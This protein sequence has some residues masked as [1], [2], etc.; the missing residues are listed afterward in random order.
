MTAQERIELLVD[1]GS[2][3]EDNEEITAEDPLHFH[4]GG[5]PYQ[6]SLRQARRETGLNE[7]IVTGHAR[8]GGQPVQ[9]AVFD[10]RFMGGSMSGAV[11]EK[12][13]RAAERAVGE[14]KPLLIVTSTGGARIQEGMLALV[15][16]AKTASAV[17]R[18]HKAEVPFFVVLAHPTTGGVFASFAS[19]A[20]VLLAEPKA[21]IGFAGPRVVE[22]LTQ[23]PLPP[24][25]HRAE[26]QFEH[27]LVDGV[28]DRRELREMLHDL[29][30]HTQVR[31][32]PTPVGEEAD[33]P[34]PRRGRPRWGPWKLVRQARRLDRPTAADYLEHVVEEFVPLHGDRLGHDDPAIVGGPGRIGEHS[35]M[36]V[37][38]ERSV[39]TNITPG[40]YRKAQR[41]MRLAAK[42]QLPVV[43][44]IDTIG[45]DP[46]IESEAAGIGNS[47]AT[48]LGLLST[49]PTPTLAVV[50]GEGG[51]GG[52]LAMGAADWV[53]MQQNAFYS[54][55]SPEGAASIIFRDTDQAAKVARGLRLT[56]HNLL[57][58]GVID[59]IVAEPPG[60]AHA[61]REAAIMALHDALCK[62]LPALVSQPLD[63]LLADRYKK[64]RSMGAF[65]TES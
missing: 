42:W 47:L 56:A 61:N 33:S 53:M 19:L 64:Y 17:E 12:I 23:E 30:V 16:M 24:G 49:L 63:V 40:G 4:P 39:E 34:L 26:F 60:G 52:A 13:V 44:F 46:R 38:Q 41:L 43:T 48:S 65:K 21:L 15:Q 27:G 29:M 2:F 3:V 57:E 32:F 8:L 45:A 59:E 37:A 54:V 31:F 20:D 22:A 62:R 28:V 7:A 35:V 14:S 1:E 9:L 50:I 58:L 25:S 11:G 36:V 6:R 10:F 5:E 51:S 18:L 55:I